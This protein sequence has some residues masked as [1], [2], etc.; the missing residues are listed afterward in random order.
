M[1]RQLPWTVTEPVPVFWIRDA[2][3]LYVFNEQRIGKAQA[4]RSLACTSRLPP[5]AVRVA[6]WM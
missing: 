2:V 3:P 4:G 6:P 1:A 5:V